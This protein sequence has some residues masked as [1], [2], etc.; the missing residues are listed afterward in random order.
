MARSYKTRAPLP[1]PLPQA[2]EGTRPAQDETS[3]SAGTYSSLSLQG[4]GRGEGKPR[5]N[6]SERD[7]IQE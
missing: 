5:H 1:D 4:E 2:G 3:I 6:V 7:T